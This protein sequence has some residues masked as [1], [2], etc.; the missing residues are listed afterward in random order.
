MGEAKAEFSWSVETLATAR[1]LGE[2]VRGLPHR[3]AALVL[4]GMLH[5]SKALRLAERDVRQEEGKA[6]VLSGDRWVQLDRQLNGARDGFRGV[7]YELVVD[8]VPRLSACVGASRLPV[9]SEKSREHRREAA[10]RAFA[11]NLAHDLVGCTCADHGAPEPCMVMVAF[12]K[13]SR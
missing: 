13:A 3:D 1:K 9:P 12:A 11:L 5:G 6:L 8:G 4:G 10:H 2:R 7:L